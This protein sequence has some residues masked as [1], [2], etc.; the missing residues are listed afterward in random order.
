MRRRAPGPAELEALDPLS[1]ESLSAS[2]SASW[3]SSGSSDERGARDRARRRRRLSRVAAV[4][5]LACAAAAGYFALAIA[6]LRGVE[7]TW[8]TAMALDAA[9]ADGDGQVRDAFAAVA[10]GGGDD[11][12]LEPLG[13]IG[14][15]VSNGLRRHERALADRRIIDAKVSDLR[16]SMVAALEFRRFQLSPTRNRIGDTP[17]QQVEAEISTQLDRWGLDR[18]QVAEPRLASLSPALTRIR[19]FA[20]VETGAVLFALDGTRLHTVDVD[21]ST[22]QHRD[23]PAPADLVPTKGGVAVVRDGRL[24]VY[25]PDPAAAAVAVIDG[26]VLQAVAAGDRSGDLWVVHG[27]STSL[28]R[29][30]VDGAAS[31]WAGEPIP[32]PTGHNVVGS[33][34]DHLVLESASG[35]LVLWSPTTRREV[36]TLATGRARFLDARGSLVLFQGPLPHSP[37]SSDFLHRYDVATD[38]RD[39]IGLPRTDA[40]SAAL[41]PDGVAAVA[42]GPLAGRLGSILFLPAD[43]TALSGGSSSGPRAAVGADAVAWAGDGESLFW[44]TPDGRIAIAFGAG[45]PTRQLLRTG[46]IG[47]DR[48]A[49]MGR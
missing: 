18:A 9:R 48:L 27:T 43:G 2:A 4:L 40:A 20:D 3:R 8:R 14:A 23:L 5:A 41:G 7:R 33:T 12:L 47:V 32:L 37:N 42:A 28:R 10:P 22:S 29:Y 26:G 31:G 13:A 39:L 34:F 44:L 19:R 24:E 30:H 17:L 46:L 36:S 25:P 21:R 35:A 1:G 16:D 15:E 11:G 6:Q 45:P 49:V 38:R